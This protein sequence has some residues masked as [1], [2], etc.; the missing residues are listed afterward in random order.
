MARKRVPPKIASGIARERMEKLF[1]LSVTAV[2]NGNNER[3]VRYVTLARRIGQKTRTPVP[4]EFSFCKN[5]GIPAVVGINCRTRIGDGRV[6]VTCLRCGS[7][8][9]MPYIREQRK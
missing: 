2:R 4:E 3:A 7:V 8:M 1:R 5:C 9:R 6:K